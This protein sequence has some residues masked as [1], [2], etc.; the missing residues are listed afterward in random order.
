MGDQIYIMSEDY[1]IKEQ[2]K[3]TEI[4]RKLNEIEKKVDGLISDR[5]HTLI[6]IILVIILLRG[7]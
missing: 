5:G 3:D 2:K 7:C 4:I 1:I 6:I